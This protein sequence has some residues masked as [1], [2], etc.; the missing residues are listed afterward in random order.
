MKKLLITLSLIAFAAT[1]QAQDIIFA[2]GGQDN[3]A[4]T[5][6][7]VSGAETVV[8]TN[9]VVVGLRRA[10]SKITIT[11]TSG[12]AGAETFTVA[13]RALVEEDAVDEDDN[14]ITVTNAV[15][16]IIAVAVGNEPGEED[17]LAFLKARTGWTTQEA[18]GFYA[19]FKGAITD[20]CR[21]K[22]RERIKRGNQ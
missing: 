14:P 5:V 16:K 10:N 13:Y 2:D 12:G 1:A 15:G 20:A 19:D 22:A 21:L 17:V 7:S 18:A 3:I 6:T 11:E 9:R 4:R 8:T